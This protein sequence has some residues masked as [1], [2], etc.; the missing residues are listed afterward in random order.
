MTLKL[1]T[2]TITVGSNAQYT[3]L[4]LI[5]LLFGLEFLKGRLKNEPL[6]FSWQKSLAFVA[7]SVLLVGLSDFAPALVIWFLL[8][9]ILSVLVING[10]I[11]AA[12]MV[13]LSNILSASKG[14]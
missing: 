10:N 14:K 9:L 11:Y 3:T 1:Q 2:P 7:A 13:S 5:G 6:S 8:L 12:G 4:L